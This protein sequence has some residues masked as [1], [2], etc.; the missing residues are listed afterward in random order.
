MLSILLIYA[1]RIK[2]EF[3]FSATYSQGE[4]EFKLIRRKKLKWSEKANYRELHV[5]SILFQTVLKVYINKY[6]Y[7]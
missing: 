1:Y 2:Y 7:Y 3:N 4:E 5:H 6:I